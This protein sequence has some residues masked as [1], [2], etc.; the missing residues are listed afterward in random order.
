M[1]FE[2]SCFEGFGGEIDKGITIWVFYLWL[3]IWSFIKI[4]QALLKNIT[5]AKNY[6][7][8]IIY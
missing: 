6:D 8:R 5:E 3:K 2:N 1:R 4:Q 7:S